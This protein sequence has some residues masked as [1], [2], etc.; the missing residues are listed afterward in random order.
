MGPMNRQLFVPPDVA[1]HVG[2]LEKQL[3]RVAE[4]GRLFAFAEQRDEMSI[5]LGNITRE[6][7]YLKGCLSVSVP[8][9]NVTGK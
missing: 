6:L 4:L 1:F 3:K 8:V 7:T 5:L 9:H 2:L